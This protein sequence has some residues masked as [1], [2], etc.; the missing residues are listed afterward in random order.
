MSTTQTRQIVVERFSVTSSG[1]FEAIVAK[2]EGYIAHP[3][4]RTLMQKMAA[5]PAL[6]DLEALVGEAVGAF[7][8][9]EFARF[10]LGLVLRKEEGYESRKSLRL[11]IGNPLVMKEMAKH[12]PDTGSYAPVTVLIDERS[13][14]IHLSYDRMASLLAPYNNPA[15]S[16]VAH[17][18]D[19]KIEA[20]LQ[21]AAS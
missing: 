2:I 14:G 5:A 10:D 12:V 16:Q 13:D 11:V 1:Q 8:L 15:A 19:S 7:G 9:M 21:R 3:E 6:A 20:M 4:V 18:L 17:E